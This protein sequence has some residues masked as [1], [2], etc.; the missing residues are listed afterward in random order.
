MRTF[1]QTVAWPEE[2]GFAIDAAV[3]DRIGF[4]R[5][6]YSHLLMELCAVGAVTSLALRIPFLVHNTM[7]VLLV[8]LLGIFFLVPKMLVRGASKGSQY[9]AAVL[10]VL[11]Y[12]IALAPVAWIVREA[13]GSFAILGQAFII[14][15]CIFTGL[16]AYVFTTRRDFSAW[17]G[18]LH[19]A[20]WGAIAIGII[21]MFFG[22]FAGSNLYSI[23]IV[24]LFSGFILYD[25]SQILHRHHV[26][27]HVAAS[28]AL[29]I[30]FVI[31]FKH[32]A[33]ILLRS[34]D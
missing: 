34:R 29:M 15:A 30:D 20:L 32:I 10:L 4:L 33:L 1:A 11:F 21:G 22:G 3:S 8:G 2:K 25:T 5:R 26:D 7:P 12:G 17:G 31:L 19:M 27:E 28:I 18:F 14:T 9:T 16:T 6:T 24:V 13:T 23:L